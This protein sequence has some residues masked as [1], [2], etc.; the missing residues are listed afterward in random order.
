MRPPLPYDTASPARAAAAK[1]IAEAAAVFPRLA[2]QPPRTEGLDPRDARLAVAIY[3]LTVQ[4]WGTLNYLLGKQLQRP[5]WKLDAPLRG[6][7]MTAGAQI[8]FMDRVPA[9][10]VV[11]DSVELTK[12]LVRKNAGGLTNAALR[13]LLRDLEGARPE[14]PWRPARDRLPL[15]RGSILFKKELLPD[16]GQKDK[17]LSLATSHPADLI[18][19]WRRELGDE[20]VERVCLAGLRHPPM[21]I[22][23]EAGFEVGKLPTD[24]GGL[25]R[26]VAHE[27]EG[28]IV[29][30]G[31]HEA[32]ITFL[33]AHP[34]R[35]VQDPAACL[36]VAASATIESGP[37]TILDLCAGRG[38]KTR[39]LAALH[40]NARIL[41]T[42]SDPALVEELRQAMCNLANVTVVKFEAVRQDPVH[43]AA[44]LVVADV[45]CSNTA[46]LARRPEAR[47]RYSPQSQ[48]GLVEAQ[49]SVLTLARALVPGAGGRVL[50]TTCSLLQEENQGQARWAGET[51]GLKLER[52]HLELPGGSEA[53][54]QDGSY[55]AVMGRS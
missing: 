3:R 13:G 14:E 23:V 29:W 12:K 40:P 47:Y 31:S 16:P 32:M 8:L 34:A 25:A 36:A 45:P 52:E 55:H 7:L 18:E 50:Y 43:Y 37:K 1:A 39:Q 15:E 11:D 4:R 10:A 27:R 19:T 5:L 51:L 6:I 17:Y 24:E 38:T 35:R 20:A 46:V 9:H 53:G 21:V 33:H 54:Y 26:A 44:D 48:A 22:A 49:R 28:F 42:D 41:A 2:A 30:R